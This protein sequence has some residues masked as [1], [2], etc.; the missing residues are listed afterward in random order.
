MAVR[1]LTISLSAISALL[2]ATNALP[3]VSSSNY[4]VKENHPVPRAWKATGPANKRETINLQIGLKQRNEGVVERHL[5]EVSDP[6]HKRYGQ[7][8][9]AAEV[10]DIV[11]PEEAS[12]TQVHAWLVE[13]GIEDIDYSPAKDW[14]SIVIPIEKAEELLQTSYTKFEHLDGHSISR[15]PEW[16]L[17]IH[18]HEHVDVVQPTT[19]F[20]KPRADVETTVSG[21]VLDEQTEETISW[22]EHTGKYKYGEQ[23][24]KGD[25]KDPSFCNVSFTTLDC[26]RTL[27]GTIDYK[28]QAADK[29]SIGINNYLNETS[30]RDDAYQ[31]LKEFRPEAAQA[32]YDF[33]FEIIDGGAN[34]QVRY[35]G[36]TQDDV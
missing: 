14:I 15:A 10:A 36:G 11:R 25:I 20:F 16:S 7:H 23:H 22:W 33:K 35:Q 26:L 6:D 12:I 3:T 1:T 17:P 21:P 34:Y 32:A 13:H 31:F 28:V 30:R 4:Q 24:G 27:Y 9:T 19:S 8:L 18:L 5:M 2:G 29:N